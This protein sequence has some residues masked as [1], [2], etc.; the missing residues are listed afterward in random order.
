[1]QT[2]QSA[3]SPCDNAPKKFRSLTAVCWETILVSRCCDCRFVLASCLGQLKG[4]CMTKLMK[5]CIGN[6]QRAD[7]WKRTRT[8]TLYKNNKTLILVFRCWHYKNKRTKS[9]EI[10][11]GNEWNVYFQQFL[12][13]NWVFALLLCLLCT[14]NCSWNKNT[15][16][17]LK[18]VYS[19]GVIQLILYEYT[20]VELV[21]PFHTLAF[22]YQKFKSSFND[23]NDTVLQVKTANTSRHDTLKNLD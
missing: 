2:S 1:M 20:N 23:P 18:K 13:L 4:N 5:V 6:N 19:Y 10:V 14:W 16:Q 7:S 3:Q 11:W 9:A 17:D 8:E 22:C 12:Y 15:L 21:L